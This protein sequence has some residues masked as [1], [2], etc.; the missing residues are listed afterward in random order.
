MSRSLKNLL[1]SV[2]LIASLAGLVV[3][4]SQLTGDLDGNY[5]VDSKDL[6]ILAWQW[7]SPGCMT[8]GCTADLDGVNSVNMADLALLANNW[9]IVDPH[10][11]ISEFMASNA[12]GLPLEEGE[13]LDGNGNSSDWIEIYNPTATA[14]NL[15]GRSLIGHWVI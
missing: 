6:K 1:L 14:I 13:L 15:G 9:Q 5:K 11:V 12:S 7:L 3:A 8:P 10:I 4:Q 2:V